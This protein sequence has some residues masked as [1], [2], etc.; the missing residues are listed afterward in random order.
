MRRGDQR[1][2]DGC[3]ALL[4]SPVV[5]LSPIVARP[6]DWTGALARLGAWVVLALGFVT[7][8][9]VRLPE[10]WVEAALGFPAIPRVLIGLFVWIVVWRLRPWVDARLPRAAFLF[11]RNV[12]LSSRGVRAHVQLAEIRYVDLERRPPPVGEAIV[13]ELHDGSTHEVCPLAWDGAAALYEAIAR[14][15]SRRE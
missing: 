14:R 13:V 5:R 8:L 4:Q 12:K 1:P 9:L 11:R 15:T 7:A 3:R 10:A 2:G 6:D